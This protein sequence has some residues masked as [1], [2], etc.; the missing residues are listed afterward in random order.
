MVQPVLF[1]AAYSV[2]TRIARLAL[3]EKGVAHAF[4]E[5]DI[6]DPAGPPAG[7]RERHPFGKVPAFTHDGFEL[8]ETAAIARY[9]DEA[10]PGP[11]LQPATPR[12]RARVAQIVGILDSYGYRPMVWDIFVERVRRPQQNE[13][14]DETAI[15]A[16]LVKTDRCLGVLEG[17]M[18]SGPCLAGEALSLADLHAAPMIAYLRAA[19]EGAVLMAE[20]PRLAAWWERISARPSMQATPSPLIATPVE[21]SAVHPNS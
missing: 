4:E 17:L 5:V 20:H 19:P 6:F 12:G 13:Q 3:L 1:G 10:F 18:G 15:A 8:Y 11:P 7:Y 21:Q 14:S 2:Y 9:V 16:A